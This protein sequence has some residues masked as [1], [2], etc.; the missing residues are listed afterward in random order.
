MNASL[1][2]TERLKLR[3]LTA[4]DARFILRLVNEPLFLHFIGDK[5]VR[6]LED[7]RQYILNGPVASYDQNGFGLFLVHV[8]TPRLLWQCVDS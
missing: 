1:I 5:G 7:A 6:N 3:K 2:E 4:D 8:K